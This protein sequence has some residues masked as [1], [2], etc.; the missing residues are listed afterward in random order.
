MLE[1]Q[2]FSKIIVANWKMNGS[3]NLRNIEITGASTD[4]DIIE[5]TWLNIPCKTGLIL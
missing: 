5:F 3:I 1:I 2:K 4:L